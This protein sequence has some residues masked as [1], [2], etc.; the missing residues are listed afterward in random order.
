MSLLAAVSAALAA[1]LADGGPPEPPATTFEVSGY[2][3]ADAVAWSEA[4][5]DELDP[6]TGAPLNQDR[7][8]VRRAR[9]HAGVTRGLFSASVEVDGNTVSGPALRLIDAE[10]SARWPSEGPPLAMLSAGLLRIPFGYDVRLNARDRFFLE[11]SR[12]AR[13]LFPGEYDL[14][15]RLQGAWRFLRYQ[16]AVMNGEPIGERA[17]PALDPNAAKDVVGRLA[18]AGT[19]GPVNI[20]VAASGLEGVGFHPGTPSTKDTVTWRDVNEDGVVQ[21][22]EI[23]VI[24]GTPATP[25]EGFRRYA[26]GGDLQLSVPVPAL[27]RFELAAEAI[28]ATNLDRGL[29]IADPVA[30]SRDVRELGFAAGAVQRLP[31]GFALGVRFDRYAPDA[32]ARDAQ[33]AQVVPLDSSLSTWAFAA[34]WSWRGTARVLLELDH[35][36]NLLGRAANGAPARLASDS[37]VARAE[38]AF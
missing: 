22:S 1:T 27:G 28:W 19:I 8:L 30:R 9:L 21:L 13:A 23:Q 5:V 4:S 10:V 36:D 7:F 17:L 25:S 6:S 24:A 32:D 11:E 34:S 20:E 18:V 35:E 15:V 33:G 31:A 2:V 26:L 14:G 38:V 3:Q 12:V 29:F 37:L 16:V